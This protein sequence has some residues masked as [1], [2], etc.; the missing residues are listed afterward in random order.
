MNDR[1]KLISGD[2]LLALHPTDGQETLAQATNLFRYIDRNF[3]HWN[4]NTVGR[5]T[6]ET[7][8][9]VYEMLRDCTFQEMFSGFGVSVNRLLTVAWSPMRICASTIRPPPI[10]CFLPKTAQHIYH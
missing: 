6:K 5:A 8:V 2:E 4:C 3:W 10:S 9:Q 7:P 1:L